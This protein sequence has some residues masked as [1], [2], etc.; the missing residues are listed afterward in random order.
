MKKTAIGLGAVVVGFAMLT[1]SAVSAQA[2]ERPGFE[3]YVVRSGDSLAK[4]SGRVFGDA[5]RWREILKANPQ[6]TNANLIFP[7]DILFVPVPLTAAP[8]DAAAGTSGTGS[9][10]LRIE[11]V[12][13]PAATGDQ[14]AAGAAADAEAAAGAGTAAAV[15]DVPVEPARPI[16]VVSPTLFRS[17]GS[18]ADHLPSIAI[19]ASEDGRLQLGT[20]EAAIINAAIPVGG[21]F[22]VVRADRRVFHPLTGRYLGWLTRILGS[23]EVT[24]RGERTSTVVLRSMNTAASLGDYLVPFDPDDT[25]EQNVLAG[26]SRP[27]CIPA[28]PCDGVIVAFNDDRNAVGEHDLAY[29]DRGTASGVV[30]G[31]RFTIYREISPEGRVTVGELQVLRAGAHTSTALVTNSINEVQI[32]NLLRAR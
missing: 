28:G 21:R 20:G 5:K 29:I 27:G 9:E 12:A 23:A 6:V 10:P 24:C 18:I 8:A 15:P 7:G 19:V 3:P 4:I 16:A 32:G 2:V 31:Q 25:L 14:G 17:A 30:P 1:L 11:T 13:A 22:T 26:K